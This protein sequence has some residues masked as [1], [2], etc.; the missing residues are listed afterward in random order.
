MGLSLS[1]L[2]LRLPPPGA[3]AAT[4]D[5][6][7]VAE[8]SRGGRV[9]WIR[10]QGVGGDGANKHTWHSTRQYK[11]AFTSMSIHIYIPIRASHTWPPLHMGFG[12]CTPFCWHCPRAFAEISRSSRCPPGTPLSFKAQNMRIGT[13]E[14][15]AH[16]GTNLLFPPPCGGWACAHTHGGVNLIV[17][18]CVCERVLWLNTHHLCMCL[19]VGGGVLG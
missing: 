14:E 13:R 18:I 5:Y 12:I 17:C 6:L 9:G 2:G 3:T 16:G 15:K 8:S 11:H 7:K 19:R 4:P 10:R 1:S